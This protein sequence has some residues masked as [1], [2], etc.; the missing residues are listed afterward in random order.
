MNKPSLELQP[1]DRAF[2]KNTAEGFTMPARLY[3]DPE[4]FRAEREAIFFKS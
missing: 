3:H 1:G 4:I 2:S